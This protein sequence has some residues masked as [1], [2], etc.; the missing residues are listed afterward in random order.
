VVS[1]ERSGRK[2]D[3]GE[4]AEEKTIPRRV[5]LTLFPLNEEKLERV[6]RGTSGV[7]TNQKGRSRFYGLRKMKYLAQQ[8][9]KTVGLLRGKRWKSHGSGQV[10]INIR[11]W[12]KKQNL[13]EVK[14]KGRGSEVNPRGNVPQGGNQRRNRRTVREDQ[15]ELGV[16]ERRGKKRWG[17]KKRGH[18]GC[19]DLK[20]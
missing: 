4:E 18:N 11:N 3:R 17:W 12:T 1:E 16:Q 20:W 13:S 9:K 14:R 6:A 5:K 7:E 8:P 19:S 10:G 2:T 15:L